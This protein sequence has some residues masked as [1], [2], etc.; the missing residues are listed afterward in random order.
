MMKTLSIIRFALLVFTISI[1][2]ISCKSNA[3][4]T[5]DAEQN[6]S[7]A[8]KELKEAKDEVNSEAAKLANAEDWKKFKSEAESKIKDNETRIAEHREKMKK[9]GKTM[10]A[11]H[12]KKIANL[13]EKNKELKQKLDNYETSQ[14]NWESFKTEFNHDMDELAA[15]FKGLTVDDK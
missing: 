13:E 12:E 6:V 1:M 3:E 8:K 9:S 10:D 15:A 7:E 14:S 2:Q 4:K 11:M 5:E